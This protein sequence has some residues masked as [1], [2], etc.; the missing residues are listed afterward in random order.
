MNFISSYILRRM[1]GI[2]VNLRQQTRFIRLNFK[3]FLPFRH[4]C[5]EYFE[6]TYQLL[7]SSFS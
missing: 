2:E 1:E 5:L 4:R 7:I 3:G 6:E